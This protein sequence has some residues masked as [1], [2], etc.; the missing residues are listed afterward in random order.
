MMGEHSKNKSP[1]DLFLCLFTQAEEMGS[2]KRNTALAK[3]AKF[4]SSIESALSENS[5]HDA[6]TAVEGLLS[7]GGERAYFNGY[8]GD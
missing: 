6:F 5:A 7:K 2:F 4:K 8:A 1:A 3:D